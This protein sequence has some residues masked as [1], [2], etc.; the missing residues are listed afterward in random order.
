MYHLFG[1]HKREVYVGH[2]TTHKIVQIAV[3]NMQYPNRKKLHLIVKDE[4][5]QIS[6]KDLFNGF[7][8]ECENCDTKMV[9][10]W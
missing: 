10:H 3:G 8:S 9:L 2:T 4:I 5:Y 6:W 7:V 1:L